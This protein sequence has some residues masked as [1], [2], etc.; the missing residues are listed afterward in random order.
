MH[1]A[2]LLGS[3]T[4]SLLGSVKMMML[5]KLFWVTCHR[6]LSAS[7]SQFK[8]SLHAQQVVIF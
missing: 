1:I 7:L 3:F 2:S 5:V 6:L 4:S 8:G